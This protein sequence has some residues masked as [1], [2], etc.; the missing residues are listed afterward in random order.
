MLAVKNGIGIGGTILPAD[1]GNRRSATT[2][3]ATFAHGKAMVESIYVRPVIH[4]LL[5]Y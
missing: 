3:G 4:I 1:T 5:V 2:I